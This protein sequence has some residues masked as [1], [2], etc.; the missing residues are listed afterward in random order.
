MDLDRGREV[1]AK[2]EGDSVEVLISLGLLEEG[3]AW[4]ES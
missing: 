3:T 2:V 1:G 4:V